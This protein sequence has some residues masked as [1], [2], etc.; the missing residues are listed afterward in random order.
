MWELVTA[1]FRPLLTRNPIRMYT[2][3]VSSL[4]ALA[5]QW[6]SQPHFLLPEIVAWLPRARQ[7]CV[8]LRVA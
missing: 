4:H 1:L 7:V 3:R 2:L 6:A 5:N 8:C